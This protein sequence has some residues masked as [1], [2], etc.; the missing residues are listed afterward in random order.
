MDYSKYHKRS[1]FV[2]NEWITPKK[3]N[4]Y[5]FSGKDT[6]DLK[7]YEDSQTVR[8]TNISKFVY[9]TDTIETLKYKIVNYCVKTENIKD[10]YL[11]A[12]C[13]SNDE[14]KILF[15]HNLFKTEIKLSKKYINQITSTFFDKKYY[16]IKE[17][18]E[19]EVF[20]EFLKLFR[21]KYTVKSLDFRYNDIFDF[22]EF[23]S[24]NPFDGV[25][26]V[27]KN[28]IRTSLMKSLLYRF[29]LKENV[30][31]FVSSN[32]VEQIDDVYFRNKSIYDADVS[33][34]VETKMSIQDKIEDVTDIV[35]NISNRL[36][37]LY[38]RVLPYS[39]D[40]KIDMKTL[41]KISDTS[42]TIPFI[43]YKSK[44]TNEYKINKI[45]L[46]DMDKKQIDMFQE[47]ELKYKDNMTNRPN[48]TII[49]Y[50][51][52]VD[53]VFFY[54]LLS[55]N[56]SYRLKYKFNRSNDIKINDIQ[57][58][59]VKLKEIL[60]KLDEFKIY[61]LSED[62]DI[63]NSNMIDIIDYNTQNTLTFKK[64]ILNDKFMD[65]I[66][67]NNPFFQYNKRLGK[68]ILQLQFI[69]TNN[70]FNTDSVT[71]YIYNH[72]ELNKIELI[73]KLKYIFKIS[74]EE[75]TDLYEEKNSKINLKISKKGK[76]IFAVRT[77]HTGVNIRLNMMSDLSIK[78]NTNN[79]QDNSYHHLL[80]F[81]LI[82]YLTKDIVKPPKSKKV[83]KSPPK[84]DEVNTDSLNFNDLLDVDPDELNMNMFDIS[85]LNMDNS[86]KVNI[87]TGLGDIEEYDEEDDVDEEGVNEEDDEDLDDEKKKKKTDYT[88]FVL[89]RLYKADKKLFLWKDITTTL[90]PY[91]SKCGAVDYRQPIV[92]NKQ[93]KDKIDLNHPGSYTGFVQT[94]ST[95]ERTKRNFYICPKIWCRVSKV[96]ITDEEYEKYGNKCP[97]PYNEEAMF[98]PKKGSK[99]NY[100]ITKD[101]LEAHWPSL[102]SENKHP[103]GMQ[104]PCCGKKPLVK[105]KSTNSNYIKSISTDLLLNE[106]Q[107][108]NL[109]FLLNKMF[110]KK[111]S[112]IG[113]L[114][115]K[116]NCYARTGVKHGENTL[117]TVIEKILGI[118]S[119][120]KYIGDNMLLEHY[121]FLNG[122]N[123]LKVFMNNDDQFKLL[124]KSEY[125][126]FQNY[127]LNNRTYIE[128]F[129][130]EEEYEHVKKNHSFELKDDQITKSIIRE[131]L[132]LNS[133]INFKN[134]I[135]QDSIRK[136]L[137]DVYHMLTH[138]WLNKEKI[139]FIFLK[140][141]KDD[142]FFI[143]PKYY[144]YMSK[145]DANKSNVVVLK[146][147][148]NYEYISNISQ[149]PRKREDELFINTK[150]TAPILNSIKNSYHSEEEPLFANE[151]V[152][153]YVISTNLKCVGVLIK[154]NVVLIGRNVQ[155]HYDDISIRKIVYTDSMYKYKMSSSFMKT[156]GK[157]ITKT[158]IENAKN[159]SKI[160]LDIFVNNTME[161]KRNEIEQEYNT[162]LYNVAKRMYNNNKLLNTL[163]VLNNKISNFTLKEK[164][165]LLITILTQNK[166]RY[167]KTINVEMMLDDLLMIPLDKIIND[168]KLKTYE[169][170]PFNLYMTF[171]DLI[172]NKLR[173]FFNND[174]NNRFV[175]FETS[176]DDYV[177][178]ID[179]IKLQ[180]QD[181]SMDIKWVDERKPIKPQRLFNLFP[182][183]EVIDEE[184]SYAKLINFANTL[185]DSVT[186]DAF[187][188]ALS[189]RIIEL[190]LKNKDHLYDNYSSS[191]RN[192]EKH[193]I[194][195]KQSSV[196]KY[197]DLI[198]N[199]DYHYSIFELNVLAEMIDHNIIIIGRGTQLV[200]DGVHVIYKKSERYIILL[201]NIYENRYSFNLVLKSNENKF[202]F[203][204]ENFSNDF[205]SLLKS[206]LNL[207]I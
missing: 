50:I 74:E 109:P 147:M 186:V 82:N 107:Y 119:L 181:I 202:V 57:K 173:D 137:D 10:L 156:F 129:D 78:I 2:L 126:T 97:P 149:K 125:K 111:T 81:Y 115:S 205:K 134:Y 24:P 21:T 42:Y 169:S 153:G 60:S 108:G 28:S 48:D 130:L 166:V 58:S 8:I 30:I 162:T 98:F 187:E 80:I 75:A 201:Y 9:E 36:E 91:S 87:E 86:P 59:F 44:F 155:L 157:Q 96:S 183:F 177:N 83:N 145:Y 143:N 124:D 85:G 165:K 14:D 199:I 192:F 160:N 22:E 154:K 38:F 180:K 158:Q 16:T 184:I 5:V 110:N 188:D 164:R 17:E 53:N 178:V 7:E 29:K 132:I 49:Y 94:G 3:K 206:R 104:L 207:I 55:E 26:Q 69:D 189:K 198:K 73:D 102:L 128:M 142:V 120:S 171:S 18:D 27:T 43:V 51:K 168:Y 72:M 56:G 23:V 41:F 161:C 163:F 127:F 66:E 11:W 133:F 65:N 89:D 203:T 105:S 71:S 144:E 54:M 67:R 113:I 197:I 1:A 12:D 112:C 70:F 151:N 46:A 116:S 35:D 159:T 150:M 179:F 175:I 45:A 52:L 193:N 135:V 33:N 170:K 200:E 152:T 64:K 148:D 190:Y 176:I 99:N 93:E 79:T 61:E 34:L 68:N 6:F 47:Q 19:K 114:D 101:G 140:V 63:F 4:V 100:F 141:Q 31:N 90:K 40:I 92:I 138:E 88:T 25:N 123:T 95:P 182:G 122:G 103:R 32:T 174:R 62:I 204:I 118:D 139:N 191:N 196:D 146:F 121:I 76:N 20:E 117:F 194:K 172:N 84:D 15:A 37:L 77:Y 13:E 185:K 39:H 195:R 106:R 131:Y 136:T 167:S